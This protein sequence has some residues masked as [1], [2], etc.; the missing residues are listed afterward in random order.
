[1]SHADGAAEPKSVKQQSQRQR[2][3]DVLS[4]AGSFTELQLAMPMVSALAAAG[5]TRPSPVQKAAIPL[6]RMGSDL[7]VQA[8]SGTGKTAVFAVVCI[9]RI[10]HS[11]N[12][13]QVSAPAAFCA[14]MRTR[15][16][17]VGGG[18]TQ[19]ACMQS[20]TCTPRILRIATAAAQICPPVPRAFN[21]RPS[22]SR[23]TA[24]WR[25]KRTPS[26]RASQRSC[27]RHAPRV[28]CLWAACRSQMTKSAYGGEQT[29]NAALPASLQRAHGS[30]CGRRRCAACTNCLRDGCCPEC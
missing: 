15:L 11:V 3:D 14:F 9:D 7:I 24:S 4:D 22:S 18:R 30:H 27:R 1:M 8:K 12:A 10:K 13:P 25:I 29:A 23:P 17:A 2:T 16:K 28:A 21:C 26:Y 20:P 19:H 6:G 5:F